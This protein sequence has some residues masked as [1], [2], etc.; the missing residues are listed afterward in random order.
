MA[1]A[2]AYAGADADA[3]ADLQ[4]CNDAKDVDGYMVMMMRTVHTNCHQIK[5]S[6][7]ISG[8]E[9]TFASDPTSFH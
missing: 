7:Y 8:T 9:K 6:I 3:D 5:R 2:G 4:G 1:D